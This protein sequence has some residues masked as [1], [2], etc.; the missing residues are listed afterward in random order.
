MFRPKVRCSSDGIIHHRGIF[1]EKMRWSDVTTV[2]S[3]KRNMI[4]YEQIFLVFLSAD[5]EIFIGELVGGFSDLELCLIGNLENFPR[6]W[7]QESELMEVGEV[8]KLWSR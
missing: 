7:K 6:N 1:K 3:E 2:F 8:K 5:K 4:T